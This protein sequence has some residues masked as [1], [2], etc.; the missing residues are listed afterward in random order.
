MNNLIKELRQ[1]QTYSAHEAVDATDLMEDAADEI[2]RLTSDGI[3]LR[4]EKKTAY[5]EIGKLREA[6][7]NITMM[8]DE[9]MSDAM[10]GMPEIDYARF[11]MSN[12][13]K[14]ARTALSVF[15]TPKDCHVCEGTG[16]DLEYTMQKLHDASQEAE[17]SL[18]GQSNGY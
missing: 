10:A 11:V 3:R 16:A 15:E 8:H 9:N 7:D 14:E 4:A 17:A 5:K 2:E 6:L 18:N 12:M 1:G 13:R